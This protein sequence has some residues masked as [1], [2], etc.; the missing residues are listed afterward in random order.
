MFTIINIIIIIGKFHAR[1]WPWLQVD[2]GRFYI[3][4]FSNPSGGRCST[5]RDHSPRFRSLLFNGVLLV[6]SIPPH[7]SPFPPVKRSD[8]HPLGED[9]AT[10]PNK[11]KWFTWVIS[12]EKKPTWNRICWT[13]C[14]RFFKF[15]TFFKNTLKLHLRNTH[16]QQQQK[17]LLFLFL[18][19]FVVSEFRFYIFQR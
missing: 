18:N 10:W 6:F 15:R 17:Y 16:F 9:L 19:I 12:P 11:Y 7:V 13:N 14:S 1:A 3:V 8:E 4:P 5:V 2:A